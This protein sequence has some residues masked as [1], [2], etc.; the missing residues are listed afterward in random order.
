M[1]RLKNSTYLLAAACMMYAFGC[2]DKTSSDASTEIDTTM[3]EPTSNPTPI[4]TY[5]PTMDPYV[6][7]GEGMKKL[8]DT[9]GVK[10]YEFTVKPGE[11]WSL[12]THPQHTVYF[13]E[14]GSLALYIQEV[15]RV[16]TI[17]FPTGMA[18][19]SGPVSDSG[20]NVGKTT[21]KMVV[22]DIY[23]SRE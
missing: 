14:G 9:L 12:H 17:T 11:S 13:L 20:R 10:M 19:I 6:R 3:V 22:A 2:N 21:I 15:G 16:D 4:D 7:G 5:D 18:L 23:K 1:K 8:G